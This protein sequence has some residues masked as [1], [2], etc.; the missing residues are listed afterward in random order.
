MENALVNLSSWCPRTRLELAKKT[1]N[2]KRVITRAIRENL[3]ANRGNFL[4]IGGSTGEVTKPISGQFRE[5]V[6]VDPAP[7]INLAFQDYPNIELLNQPF[8]HSTIDQFV[9]DKRRFDYILMSHVLYYYDRSQWLDVLNRV[10]SDLLVKNGRIHIFLQSK[11]SEGVQ[12]YDQYAKRVDH[13]SYGFDLYSFT[14]ELHGYQSKT[15]S[16]GY[17]SYEF[18]SRTYSEEE[19]FQLVLF[20]IGTS[21][22]GD[23]TNL[24]EEIMDDIVKRYDNLPKGYRMRGFGDFVQI[25]KS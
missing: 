11:T 20:A 2:E 23:Y 3:P 22:L 24:Y 4:D 16:I 17:G 9:S 14:S 12:L 13:P 21:R 19:L 1:S 18:S 15:T 6:I 8:D 7:K 10:F 25:E 5:T